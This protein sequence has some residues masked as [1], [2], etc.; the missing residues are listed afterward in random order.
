M[1]DRGF[2]TVRDTGGTDWGIKAAVDQGLIAGPRL[3]IA[4]RS[5]GPTG[6]HAR[7]AVRADQRRLP[8][9]LLQRLRLSAPDRRRRG[10]CAPR[11]AR[12]DAPGLRPR[13]DHG[14][15]RRRLALRPARFAAVLGGRDR[16]GGRGGRGLRPLCLRPRLCRRGDRA[17]R[18]ER[19]AHH[20]ARQ[21][22]RRCPRQA[23]GEQAPISS[24]TSSPMSR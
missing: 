16:R 9:R 1:L 21:P 17:G 22:D 7:S 4:G 19:R 15:G 14:L 3:F 13:E 12:A 10:R 20:R 6:G 2:T 18:R 5:I 23:D 11:G 24:P 8:L